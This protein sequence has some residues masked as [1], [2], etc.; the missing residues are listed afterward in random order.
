MQ[1]VFGE[2]EVG[3]SRIRGGRAI[4]AGSGAMRRLRNVCVEG[5][6]ERLVETA[7]IT[8]VVA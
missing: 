2:R 5:L 7:A 4:V 1:R 6:A 3:G 8:T